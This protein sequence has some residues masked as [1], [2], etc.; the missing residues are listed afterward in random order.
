MK[1]TPGA[2]AFL[3]VVS[4]FLGASAALLVRLL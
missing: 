2:V 3:S 4:F 1:F